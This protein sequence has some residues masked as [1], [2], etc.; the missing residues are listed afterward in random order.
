M[1]IHLAKDHDEFGLD[2]L[3][4]GKR[5][6]VLAE[7]ERGAVDVGGEVAYGGDDAWVEG[8]AVGKVATETHSLFVVSVVLM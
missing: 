5:V 1:V 4:A 8:A 7:A 2:I 3:S 6:V